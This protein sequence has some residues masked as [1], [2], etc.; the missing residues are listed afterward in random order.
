MWS[1]S[2]F[3]ATE[4]NTTWGPARA[5]RLAFWLNSAAAR[6]PQPSCH[7]YP[8][9]WTASPWMVSWLMQCLHSSKDMPPNSY[10]ADAEIDD[11]V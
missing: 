10:A 3:L 8:S 7:T 4:E 2:V 9:A 1:L 11:L 5:R 6:F